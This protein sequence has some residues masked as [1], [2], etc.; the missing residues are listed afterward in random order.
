ML[1]IRNL[2][3]SYGSH[4]VLRDVSLSVGRGEMVCVCGESGCGKSS[5]LNAVLGFVDSDGEIEVDG[6]R[7]SD[8]SVAQIRRTV[9]FVPQ[10]LALPCNTVNSMVRMPFMFHANRHVTF[11]DDLLLREWQYLN[12]HP[13]LLK[14]RVSEVSGGERQRIMLSVAGLL[15]KPLLLV[16]EPTSAL[17]VDSVLRVARYFRMLKEE[18]RMAILAV[19]HQKEFAASCDRI[20]ELK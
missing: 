20:I 4:Q 16:D 18:R 14:K 19:S 5:L 3:L 2:S 10:E 7:L 8:T 11:S 13:G 9:A 17:D 12:L 1:R 6:Q 15:C